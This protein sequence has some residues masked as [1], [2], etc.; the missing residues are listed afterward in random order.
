MLIAIVVACFLLKHG[1]SAVE[2]DRVSDEKLL[3]PIQHRLLSS[4]RQVAVGDTKDK[5]NCF[6]LSTTTPALKCIQPE[7]PGT[8]NP[9]TL[10]TPIWAT[11]VIIGS[12]KTGTDALVGMLGKN[13]H[14]SVANTAFAKKPC[15]GPE[16]YF[17]NEDE[18]VVR[19]LPRYAQFFNQTIGSPHIDLA[20]E[21]TP[22][23]AYD[24]F[25]PYRARMFLPRTAKFIYT[26]RNSTE[27]QISLYL[28]RNI[29]AQNKVSYSEYIEQFLG[30]VFQKWMQCRAAA[31]ERMLI[32]N[33]HNNR[34]WLTIDSLNDPSV[35]SWETSHNIER[36]LYTECH[37]GA[38]PAG[39]PFPSNNIH[40]HAYLHHV[41]LRRW[42]HAVG[43]D[44]VL[45]V[46]N[47]DILAHPDRVQ[48]RVAEFL[49]ID[50]SG[51]NGYIPE[52]VVRKSNFKRLAQSQQNLDELSFST[53]HRAILATNELYDKFTTVDDSA[54]LNSVC[55]FL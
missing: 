27:A 25:A 13:Q 9:R 36:Q 18:E 54:F 26:L 11:A 52:P 1:L 48:Q 30:P 14:I 8:S 3:M 4:A 49:D 41:N 32:P 23:Y 22:Q 31:F 40:F 6:W 53:M 42:I 46:R 16:I 35:F 55:P 28:F 17:L 39:M 38:Y 12:F 7:N 29:A 10:S 21:K 20:V 51:W 5:V 44:R 50:M 33:I 47:D 34:S 19:G 2:S 37:T 45:C 24:L 43:K 15:C